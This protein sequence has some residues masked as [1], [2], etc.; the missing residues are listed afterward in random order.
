VASFV[1]AIFNRARFLIAL[2]FWAFSHTSA[3]HARRCEIN[4]YISLPLLTTIAL[5][6]STWLSQVYLWGAH[7]NLMLLVVLIWAMV[8]SLDEGLILAFTGGLLIDLLS[9]GPMGGMT[10]ALVAAAFLAGQS[11]G[12]GLGLSM[13]RLLSLA[14]LSAAAYHLILLI[15]LA[16]VGHRIDWRFELL[17]VAG[18]SMLLN[19]LLVP[20]ARQPLA[21][22]AQRIQPEGSTL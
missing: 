5:I 4:F 18:P 10:L 1:V 11:W 17:H 9:S 2:D 3:L 21:W 22:L 15:A 19:T 14:F 16:L 7:P 13:V 20:F 12:R 6:Q 8:R